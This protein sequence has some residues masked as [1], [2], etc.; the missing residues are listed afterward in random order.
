MQH[1]AHPVPATWR[2]GTI[3]ATAARVQ[4][5]ERA[6]A[7]F[8]QLTSAP[9][10][11]LALR[12]LGARFTAIVHK[13]RSLTQ[14]PSCV[15]RVGELIIG[16][17][18]AKRPAHELRSV[19]VWT[20][21][22]VDELTVGPVTDADVLHAVEVAKMLEAKENEAE[23]LLTCRADRALTEG[24][25]ARLIEAK[26][27]EVAADKDAI[28]KLQRLLAQKRA[29]RQGMRVVRGGRC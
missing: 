28:A 24:D 18:L 13:G 27:S 12:A 9:D 14:T 22:L 4:L 16:L 25:L 20:D 15:E 11:W 3:P 7:L 26:A 2:G 29:T 5:R 23:A 21:A 17:H 19:G 10:I 1:V 6:V 8:H